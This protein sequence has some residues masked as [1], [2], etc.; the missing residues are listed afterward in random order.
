MATRPN[1]GD[2]IVTATH[3]VTGTVKE[4]SENKNGTFRVR[5]DVN[6]ADRWTTVK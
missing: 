3:K 1:I 5:L 6:G 4:V 2:T